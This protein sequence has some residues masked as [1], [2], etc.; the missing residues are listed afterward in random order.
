VITVTTTT[1]TESRTLTRSNFLKVAGGS[2]LIVSFGV[3][4]LVDAAAAD[5]GPWPDVDPRK[6]D[7]WIA[8]HP[9][10]TV[11]F[12]TG[13]NDLGQGLETTF[14]QIVA[15]EMDLAFKQVLSV[16]SDTA[17][18]PHQGGAS[19]STGVTGGGPAVRNAAAEAR[20]VLVERAS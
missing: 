6:L 13:K 4:R 12:Y 16:A 11:T 10:N 2:M 9:D 18:T 1:H 15:E 8:V 5:A 14:R 19:G 7:S 3:P 20:R 17:M